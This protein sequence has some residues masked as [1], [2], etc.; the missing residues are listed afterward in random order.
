L[1]RLIKE[2]SVGEEIR[3]VDFSPEGSF[4]AIGSNQGEIVLY[5]VSSDFSIIE[6]IDSNRQRK[7]CITDIK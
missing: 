7:A 1:K 5:K 6:K 3:C 2:H 4:V